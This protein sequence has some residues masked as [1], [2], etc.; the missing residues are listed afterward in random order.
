MKDRIEKF[1]EKKTKD[2]NSL[3][4]KYPEKRSLFIDWQE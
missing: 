1:L 2:L 4:E 3:A